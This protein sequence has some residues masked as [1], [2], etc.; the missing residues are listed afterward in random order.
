VWSEDRALTLETRN[1]AVNERFFQ[2]NTDII[3]QVAGRKIIGSINHQIVGLDDRHRRG[4]IEPRIVKFDAD[5]GICFL[6]AVASTVDFFSTNIASSVEDLA[7]EVGGID[8]IKVDHPQRA[9]SGGGEIETRRRPQT[10]S[11]NKENAGGFE[12][13]LTIQSDTG[14]RQVSGVAG[15]FRGTKI[16]L[17][18]V[19]RI[20]DANTH[21]E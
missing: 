1:R 12:A 6:Q 16:H 5:M 7:L 21:W 13:F 9:D 2:K 14:K 19:L 11:T 15:N 17:G 20:N 3:A 18:R 10:T 4:G 8:H